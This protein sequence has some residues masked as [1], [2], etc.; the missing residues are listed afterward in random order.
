MKNWI[1]KTYGRFLCFI[2]KHAWT[3]FR[4]MYCVEGVYK[5]CR[6]CEDIQTGEEKVKP[7]TVFE[8][9]ETF[10][11]YQLCLTGIPPE[12]LTRNVLV[13]VT[14][15]AEPESWWWRLWHRK[16]MKLSIVSVSPP[17]M[18]LLKPKTVLPKQYVS[19]KIEA[20]LG[21]VLEHKH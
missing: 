16:S 7:G 13:T 3:R 1:D 14:Y 21:R 5:R 12:S 20:G 11:P 8:I 15:R 17:E 4:G 10:S 18:I 2:G 9:V 19:R 6:R